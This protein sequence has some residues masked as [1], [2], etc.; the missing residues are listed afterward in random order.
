M[1]KHEAEFK[2]KKYSKSYQCRYMGHGYSYITIHC[3]N[4]LEDNV[5]WQGILNMPYLKDGETIF[6]K[7]LNETVVVSTV[8]KSTDGSAT[9]QIENYYDLV[10][11][12]ST[13]K[14]R[15]EAEK[16]KEMFN[17]SEKERNERLEA[18]YTEVKDEHKKGIIDWILGS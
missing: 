2:S 17:R 14:S 15:L 13:E 1:F 16:M 18:K 11:D 8:L 3:G 4:E 7:D 9:Y 12:E 5:I 6:L 10:E